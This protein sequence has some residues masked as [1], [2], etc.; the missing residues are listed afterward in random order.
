MYKGFIID[1]FDENSDFSTIGVNNFGES[2]RKTLCSE[3]QYIVNGAFNSCLSDFIIQNSID[4]DVILDGSRILDTYF[5][6][7]KADI[8]ISHSHKD[9]ET[10]KEFAKLIYVKTGLRSFIDSEVWGYA[11]DLLRKID[12]S[13]CLNSDGSF[14]YKKRNIS[15]SYVHMMLN[16]A[17]LSMI[18]RCECL[19]FLSTPN[20]FN[21]EQK[22]KN[23][24][25]SPWIYFELSMANAIE[26]R[27]PCRFQ[28]INKSL[29]EQVADSAAPSLKIALKPKIENL[30]FCECEKL[31]KWLSSCVT[32]KRLENLDIF[33]EKF[34]V[35]ENASRGRIHG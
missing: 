29:L 33:Y 24:T 30:T 3:A 18:D 12:N 8:F 7:V 23:T 1:D 34:G 10:A 9:V 5:P 35:Q 32:A 26:K 17:L 11:D 15:T 27:I 31:K 16:T 19:F 13:Y 25:F 6:N 14:S 2:L 21:T 20:S 22:I 4:K 28:Q